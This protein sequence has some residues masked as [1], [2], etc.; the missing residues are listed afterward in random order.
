M[1]RE[2][3]TLP[4]AVA[5][6][7]INYISEVNIWELFQKDAIGKIEA[8]YK[9]D[10][11]FLQRIFNWIQKPLLIFALYGSIYTYLA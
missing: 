2:V 1:L 11:L 4:Q 9:R 5:V 8:N 6:L 7:F 3:G 10:Y